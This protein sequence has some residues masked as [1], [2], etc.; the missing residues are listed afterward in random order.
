[1]MLFS[2]IPGNR[3]GFQLEETSND[4]TACEDK[5]KISDFHFIF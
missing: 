2:K 1:M 5:K 3:Y 4:I